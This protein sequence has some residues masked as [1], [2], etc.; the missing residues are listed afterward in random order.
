[1]FETPLPNAIGVAAIL[2]KRTAQEDDCGF[3][4]NRKRLL[5]EES[6]LFFVLCDGMGG[7]VGGR[8]ASSTAVSAAVE[9][10]TAV[11][12]QGNENLLLGLEAANRAIQRKIIE[13]PHL[14]DM[15]TTFL[16]ILIS[17]SGLVWCSV[18]DTALFLYRGGE[19]QRLNEDHSV[20]PVLDELVAQNK[21]EAGHAAHDPNRSVLRSALTGGEIALIDDQPDPLIL[22]RG[23]K[24]LMASDG[25]DTLSM[26]EVTE[27]LSLDGPAQELASR[28]AENVLGMD[29]PRQ[30]NTTVIV[31]DPS[32]L[33]WPLRIAGYRSAEKREGKMNSG[34]LLARILSFFEKP[35][36]D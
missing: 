23:D 7:H 4:V 3:T 34:S 24:I 19:I 26:Q 17:K 16:S 22:R 5:D 35:S 25:L 2:G 1:M 31:I 8:V 29:K 15:G 6:K 18:G 13:E 36:K 14:S 30:D 32:R 10:A 21:I 28:L 11:I 33:G 20:G 27:I 12:S 9:E